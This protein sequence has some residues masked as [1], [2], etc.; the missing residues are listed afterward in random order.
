MTMFAPKNILV[1]T[2]FSEYS[3][4]ALKQAVEIA[5][6][7]KSKVYLL[8]VVDDGIQQCAGDYC[9]KYEVLEALKLEIQKASE[10]KLKKEA[11][12]IGKSSQVDIV[13]DVRT[14]HPYEEI[15]QEQ[16]DKKIDL[17]VIASHGKTGLLKHLIGSVAEKVLRGAKCPVLLVKA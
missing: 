8:H 1:P 4:K 11:N 13:F 14:G 5:S 7:F 15:L 3:D 6:T 12:V 10:E 17:I 16:E 2:D 9:L